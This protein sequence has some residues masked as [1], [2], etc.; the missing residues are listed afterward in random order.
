MRTSIFQFQESYKTDSKSTKKATEQSWRVFTAY[1]NE[2]QIVIDA[3][4]IEKK[5]LDNILKYFFMEARQ[6]DGKAYTFYKQVY[7]VVNENF[8]IK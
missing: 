7:K 5:D 8:K 2:K 3:K 4:S 1:C 6:P